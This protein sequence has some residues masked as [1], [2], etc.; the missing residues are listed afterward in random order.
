MDQFFPLFDVA[1]ACIASVLGPASG[2]GIPLM[3]E[4]SNDDNSGSRRR[5]GV[6]ELDVAVLDNVEGC[7]D[8]L[9]SINKKN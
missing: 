3:R 6:Q 8:C 9:G 2:T 5:R 7:M 4:V 1:E